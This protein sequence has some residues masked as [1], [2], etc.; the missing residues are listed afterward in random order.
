MKKRFVA[1][2]LAFVL[3]CTLLAG[4]ASKTETPAK[5]EPPA[6]AETTTETTTEAPAATETE[7]E[8]P[9]EEADPRAEK[10][11]IGFSVSGFDNENFVYMDQLMSKYCSENNI[12]YLTAAHNSESSALM[13]IMENFMAA[14]VNGV[15][16][17]NFEPD[18]INGTLEEM[19]EKGIKVVSYDSD[20][21]PEGTTG[22]WI[23]SNYDTGVVIGTAAADFINSELDGVC[24]YFIMNS[25]VAFMQDRVQGIIDTIAE[26]CPNSTLAYEP[27]KI[28]LA[29]AV[30]TFSNM[31]T[32][33]PD[34]QVVCTGYSTCATNIIAEWL[35]EIQRKG[36][37]L[38]KYGVFTCDC[39]NL[40]LEYMAQ[41]VK[42]EN[43]L[44][45]T[46][47]LGL[48]ELV[49]MGMITQCEAAIRGLDCEYAEGEVVTFPHDLVDL[50]NYEETA[51]KYNVEI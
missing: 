18:S 6:A 10:I 45:S 35:P 39:T 40:D 24:N 8:A 14:G 51:A 7:T 34:V 49:P 50:T 41:T 37:D 22:C 44:R 2:F 3:V 16:F 32:A 30:E 26:K 27:P 5:T 47:D 15:I 38:S 17:Q 19:I 29:E 12:E 48:K 13:E 1:L 33:C 36:G 21:V 4:C 20:N 42:G 31:L 9:A 23:C 46:V 28:V 11:K 43:I 25:K